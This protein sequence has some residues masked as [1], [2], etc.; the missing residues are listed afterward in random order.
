MDNYTAHKTVSVKACLA[1]RP[2]YRAHFTPTPASRIDRV[3][4]WFAEPARKQI[5][6]GVRTSTKRLEADIRAFIDRRN[7]NPKPFEWPETAGDILASVE[8]FRHRAART[9]CGEL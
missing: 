2:R 5:Q 8:R 4:R 6:R 1:R 3:E 9:L 7:Q